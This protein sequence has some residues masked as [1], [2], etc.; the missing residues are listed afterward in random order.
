[1]YPVVQVDALP[2]A[3]IVGLGLCSVATGFGF[4]RMSADSGPRR[5]AMYSVFVLLMC[6]VLLEV[7][8]F[9]RA[10]G[11]LRAGMANV[12][13]DRVDLTVLSFNARGTGAP[14]IVEA[15]A[16][17][18]A[19]VMLLVEVKEQ[20]ATEVV[21]RLRFR[22][23]RNQVF[24]GTGS[25]LGGAHE[26]AVIIPDRFGRYHETVSPAL[27]FG[28]LTVAPGEPASAESN[29][30]VRT[31]PVLSAVHSISPLP[32]KTSST[33]WK[34]QLRTAVGLCRH[35]SAIIGG[36]FNASSAQISHVIG[37][38]CLEAS[39]H[40]GRGGVGTWPTAMPAP[41]GASIDHQL[42][43]RN[44]WEPVGIRFMEIGSSDHRGIAVSYRHVRA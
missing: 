10:G 43:N 15:V 44:S 24:T 11:F 39:S 21:E 8:L 35:D 26:V 3:W 40:L 25:A 28:S 14:D 32:G 38:D 7:T 22:G 12:A 27:A 29:F 34:H 23:S 5:T 33:A 2:A 6:V 13:S 31:R 17:A 19:D 1:M 30:A 16:H 42:A 41:F 9:A 37:H 4:R 20:V 18:E 36:D